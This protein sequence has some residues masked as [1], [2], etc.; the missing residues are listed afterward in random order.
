MRP[1]GALLADAAAL[2]YEEVY[3]TEQTHPAPQRET[4][5]LCQL[6]TVERRRSDASMSLRPSVDPLLTMY[7]PRQPVVAG[8][9]G[10]RL[11]SRFEGRPIC[12]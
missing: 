7:F 1:G 3:E 12:N 8:G 9:N 4:V 6:H 2:E 11:F 5:D 10:F